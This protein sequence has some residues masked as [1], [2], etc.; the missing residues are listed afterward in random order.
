MENEAK[1]IALL[2]KG[3]DYK[4]CVEMLEQRGFTNEGFNEWRSPETGNRYKLMV[5]DGGKYTTR[6][7]LVTSEGGQIINTEFCDH[8]LAVKRFELDNAKPKAVT[9]DEIK[10]GVIHA[11]FKFSPS[12]FTKD[13]QRAS[14]AGDAYTDMLYTM[15]GVPRGERI[16]IKQF[17]F[18]NDGTEREAIAVCSAHRRYDRQLLR[19]LSV[20]S[21]KLYLYRAMRL[22]ED[23]I[24]SL[25][26]RVELE[27][28]IGVEEV[29]KLR[30]SEDE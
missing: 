13:L 25:L 17:L 24:D 1:G 4:D 8:K 20:G 30:F 26:S 11:L 18:V 28:K 2:C 29:Q 6:V 22:P 7:E 27:R 14:V 23:M 12:Q 3:E 5:S 9:P 10:Q 16:S 21:K 19:T 15:L